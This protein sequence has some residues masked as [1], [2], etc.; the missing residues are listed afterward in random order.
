MRGRAIRSNPIRRRAILTLSLIAFGGAAALGHG[1]VAAQDPVAAAPQLELVGNFDRPYFVTRA[2][3]ASSRGCCSSSR[4]RARSA[5]STAARFCPIPSSTSAR[6][7]SSPGSRGL[8]SIAFPSDYETSRLFYAFFINTAGNIEVDEFA[9]SPTDPTDADESTH[10]RVIAIPHPVN[11]NH[12]GGQLQFGPDGMLWM[13]TGDGGGSGDP[14]ENA[15]NISSLLGK[16][17]RIDPRVSGPDPYSVPADNPFVGLPGRDEIWSF[18]LRNPWRFSFNRKRIVIADVGQA[19]WEEISYETIAA[20]ARRELRLGQLRGHPPVR[21]AGA[22]RPRAADSRVPEPH[23]R[24]QLLDHRWVRLARSGAPGPVRTLRLRRLLRRRA[25]QPD[26]SPDRR[27]RRCPTRPHGPVTDL[28][29]RR[30]REEPL[31]R[32]G[33]RARLSP[34][35]GL[36]LGTAARV[37]CT[38]GG[39]IE[40]PGPPETRGGRAWRARA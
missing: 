19:S 39:R 4:G 26:P 12:N 13:S 21:G 1:A 23:G 22:D 17:L 30:T 14:G 32:D 40:S 29:R 15:E 37:A 20:R 33:P 27:H 10:R 34:H 16:L 11:R 25:A 6:G 5:P 7:S 2:P 36:A 8:L 18:G 31:R 38:P 9:V 28:L 35:S 24:R 3:G